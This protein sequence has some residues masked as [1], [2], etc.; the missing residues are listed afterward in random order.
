[1]SPL[2]LQSKTKLI[3]S[4]TK[5]ILPVRSYMARPSLDALRT[6][7]IIHQHRTSLE[8]PS[9]PY[10]LASALQLAQVRERLLAR[11]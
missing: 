11:P 2:S 8:S 6:L 10:I 4:K 7:L 3:Q 5:L 9:A 1:M